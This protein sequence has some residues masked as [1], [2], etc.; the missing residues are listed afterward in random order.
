MSHGEK[1]MSKTLIQT[2][3]VHPSKQAENEL[4]VRAY[5]EYLLQM[6]SSKQDL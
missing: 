2:E 6:M 5:K 1:P 4:T 3:F